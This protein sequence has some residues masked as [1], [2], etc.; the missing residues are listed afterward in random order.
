MMMQNPAQR[1]LIKGAA[2]G[3][4]EPRVTNATAEGRLGN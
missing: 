4:F 3:Q 1:A 2:S